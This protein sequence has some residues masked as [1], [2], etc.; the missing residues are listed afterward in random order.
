MASLANLVG[1]SSS[2]REAWGQ[3]QIVAPIPFAMKTLRLSSRQ[4]HSLQEGKAGV[5]KMQ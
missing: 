1:E 3:N 5:D 2:F 4:V